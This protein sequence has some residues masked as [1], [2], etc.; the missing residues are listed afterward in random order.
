M[1]GRPRTGNLFKRWRGR[2]VRASD[3]LPG[4]FYLRV[5]IAGKRQNLC[6]HT[7]D[8]TDADR[9]AARFVGH[10][11]FSD[12]E[13]YL[14]QLIE[15]GRQA[16]RELAGLRNADAAAMLPL[17][18]TWETYVGSKRRPNSGPATLK[19]YRFQWQAFHAWAPQ[20]VKTLPDLSPRLCEEYIAHLE[21]QGLTAAT[22][23]KHIG[24]LR[25]V[26]RVLFPGCANPW[27]GLHSTAVSTPE[28]HRRLSAKETRALIHCATGEWRRLLQIGYYTGLRLVDASLLDWSEIDLPGRTISLLPRKTAR[29]RKVPVRIPIVTALAGILQETPTSQRIGPVLPATAR[30]YRTDPSHG[31]K[32]LRGIFAIAG[33]KD[34][35]EG[36]ASFH[37]LRVT[38]QSMADDAGVSRVIARSVLGHSGAAM[39][40]TY[41]RLDLDRARAQVEK[42]IAPV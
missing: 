41:S 15:I 1:Q 8:R 35:K 28:C 25:L 40:D 9:E 37:S 19:A 12:R 22:V 29:R 26:F 33:V 34:T 23:N 36:K 27:A 4:V 31:P 14:R 5:Q 38:W 2:Y 16:E 24:L 7:K 20:M 42:A 17:A 13:N 11:K 10:I 21:K 32:V 6:L 39:S 18:S 30:R 3:T